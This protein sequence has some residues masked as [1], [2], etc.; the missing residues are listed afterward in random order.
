VLSN[1]LRKIRIAAK[2]SQ[3]YVAAKAGISRE[4][5]NRVEH[6]QYMPTVKVFMRLC[7]V[8]GTKAWKVLKRVEEHS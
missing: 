5:L 2:L 3:E 1:E 4:Y 6:G 7:A 8:L